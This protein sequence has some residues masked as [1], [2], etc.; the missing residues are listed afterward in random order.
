MWITGIFAAS[1]NSRNSS[2]AFCAPTPTSMTGFLLLLISLAAFL[3]ARGFG[4]GAFG[5]I[6]STALC[7][8]SLI[9]SF[10]KSLGQITTATPFFSYAV[11]IAS[12]TTS[13]TLSPFWI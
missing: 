9:L 12:L 5:R 1:T 10:N 3:T 2:R 4:D 13:K 7:V 8:V 6:V 11:R